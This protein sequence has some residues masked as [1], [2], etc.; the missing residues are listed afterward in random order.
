MIETFLDTIKEAAIDC[1]LFKNHNMID[2][3]YSCFSFNEK[4]YFEGYIGP[5]YKYDFYDD[6]KLDNG[7]NSLNSIKKKI[8][9]I[10]IKA[11]YLINDSFSE[12]ECYWYNQESGVIYDYD[13]DYPVGKIYLENGIANKLDK[14]TYIIDELI[15]IP[16]VNVI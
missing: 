8:K 10:K 13:L 7:S 1:A 16:E 4:S 15:N 2:N 5:I 14:N 9:V 12:P 6:K 11:V 3:V